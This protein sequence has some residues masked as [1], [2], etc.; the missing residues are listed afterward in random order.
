MRSAK[1]VIVAAAL[2]LPL[3]IGAPGMA[4]AD[5]GHGGH[6][7]KPCHSKKCHKDHKDKWSQEQDQE[8]SQEASNNQSN[9]NA[10][11]IY[12]WSVGSKGE[13]NAM[14]W[15]D[16]SNEGSIEQAEGA[17]QSAEQEEEHE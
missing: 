17:S 8:Q 15:T 9:S 7:G 1:R 2:G 3:M 12:Q 6:D 13:Q 14:S 10:S 4:L 16:Q 11:P 5:D